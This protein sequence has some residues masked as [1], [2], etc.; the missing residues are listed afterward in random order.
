M[1]VYVLVI[2]VLVLVISLGVAERA[3][4]LAR[5]VESEARASS[6]ADL[7]DAVMEVMTDGVA[8]VEASGN[9]LMRNPVAER[10]AGSSRRPGRAGA[11]EDHGFFAPDGSVLAPG[12]LPSSRALRGEVVTSQDLLRIDPETGEQVVLSIGAMPLDRPESE[13][14]P[15]AVLVLH[16]VTRERTHRRELQAFAGTVAHDLKAPLTGVGSWAEILGDQ[17]DVLGVDVTEPRSSLR[18]IESSAARMDQLISDL[19][20]YSQAQSGA[21]SPEALSL[22]GMVDAVARE[23]RD[24]SAAPLPVFEYAALGRVRADRVLVGQLL[25][26]VIGNATKYVAPGTTPRVRITSE[27]VADMVE[28]R[29]SD[30]GIG[31]PRAERGQIFDSFYR[32]SSSG[33]YPGTGLGLAICARAVERHGGRISAR[34]GLDGQGT[35]LI[36]TLPADTAP[37]ADAVPD[38]DLDQ[39][40]EKDVA[41]V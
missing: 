28:V 26:N 6:R 20:A 15:L 4:L 13:G 37:V 29:V 41:A 34:Q 2:T 23:L 17:L 11:M 24:A 35:T 7:L 36:F 3:A 39:V 19:L 40:E 32:A 8:V 30:N 33:S 9:V 31:I 21:L 12:D 25:A 10:L 18:R 14:G 22:T 27:Q 1:Q 38:R 16:D 5:V